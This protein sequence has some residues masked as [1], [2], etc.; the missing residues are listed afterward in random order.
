MFRLDFFGRQQGLSISCLAN[1]S[2]HCTV[3]CLFFIGLIESPSFS[4]T[5]SNEHLAQGD[6]ITGCLGNRATFSRKEI[7]MNSQSLDVHYARK[8]PS[9]ILLEEEAF[10]FFLKQFL[11]NSL[12][13]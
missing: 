1:N 12:A 10:V 13:Q 4:D 5:T 9:K 8:V 6:F 11:V 7:F 3:S 2:A